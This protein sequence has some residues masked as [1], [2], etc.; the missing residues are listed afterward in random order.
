ME[1]EALP[2][3]VADANIDEEAGITAQ[4]RRTQRK[5]LAHSVM[6]VHSWQIAL[7]C[8][9]VAGFIIYMGISDWSFN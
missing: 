9:G 4:A 8:G 2:S 3:D 6:R 7:I 5:R 1:P